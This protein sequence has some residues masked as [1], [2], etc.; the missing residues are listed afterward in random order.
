MHCGEKVGLNYVTAADGTPKCPVCQNRLK[1]DLVLYGENLDD[2][3][4]S[5]AMSAIRKCDLL[6]VGGTSLVVQPAAGMIMYRRPS[7][8]LVL[9][10]RDATPYDDHADLVIHHDLGAVLDAVIPNG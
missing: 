4:V 6:I 7:C 5:S 10:N 8:R 2:A 9:I 1:P 3:V